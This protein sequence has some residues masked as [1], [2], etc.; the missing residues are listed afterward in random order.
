M[1]VWGW[2]HGKGTQMGEIHEDLQGDLGEWCFSSPPAL[3]VCSSQLEHLDRC[4]GQ[5][6]HGLLL[7]SPPS[8]PFSQL[9]ALR[10]F[11]VWIVI[12]LIRIESAECRG[13]LKS[14]TSLTYRQLK[15]IW[16]S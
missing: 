4:E 1:N 15:C 6:V 9:F 3:E 8:Q 16:K 13:G 12:I 14:G 7:G 5:A 11:M 2:G 10:A